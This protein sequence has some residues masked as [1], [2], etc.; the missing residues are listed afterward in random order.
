MATNKERTSSA[1]M[2]KLLL[3]SA[4]KKEQ[5]IQQIGSLSGYGNIGTIESGSDGKFHLSQNSAY[6]LSVMEFAVVSMVYS[7]VR[8][9]NVSFMRAPVTF[10][11]DRVGVRNEVSV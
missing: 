11:A 8:C 4:S 1:A 9:E 5:E 6:A 3:Q 7:A 10:R 2:R